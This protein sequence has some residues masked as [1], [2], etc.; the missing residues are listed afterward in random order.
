M[1]IRTIRPDEQKTVRNLILQGLGEHFE[2]IKP[3]LNPDLDDITSNYILA[4]HLFLVCEHQGQI[5]GTG[6]LV[7]ED[8]QTGRIVRVSVAPSHRRRGIAR[9]ITHHLISRAPQQGYNQIVVE[10]N[11]D[12]HSAIRLYQNCG[13]REYDRRNGEIHFILNLDSKDNTR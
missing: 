11:D 2:T 8:S 12:W 7:N 13:F 10:T 4:G 6:A 3:E 9:Q 1:K 5:I